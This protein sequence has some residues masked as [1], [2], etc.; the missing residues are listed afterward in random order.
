M[1]TLA[2]CVVFSL[3]ALAIG[4]GQEPAYKITVKDGNQLVGDM[5]MPIDPELRILAA[6]SNNMHFGLSL[7]F[8]KANGA[9]NPPNFFP[10]VPAGKHPVR[11]TC[12]PN[13]SIWPAVRVDGVV[14]NP[15]FQPGLGGIVRPAALPPDRHGK[16]RQG[17][18]FTWK[19][20]DL[21]CTQTVEVVPSKPYPPQANAKRKLDT[22]RIGYLVENK[23]QKPHEVAWRTCVDILINNN[24]GA[25]YAS[26]TTHPN[27]VLNGVELKGKTFPEFLQVI[28]I[29]NLNAPGTVAVMTFKMGAK[30]D[31]PNRIVLTNLPQVGAAQWD[32]VAQQAGD[33]ACALFW[34]AKTI[35]PGAKR[36]MA[37]AYGGGIASNPDGEGK[38][39]VALGGNLEPGK[40]FS[41]QAT[42]EDP[43]I[44]QTL[45]LEL[46]AGV[47]RVEGSEIE[48]VAVTDDSPHGVVLWRARVTRPGTYDLKVHSSTGVTLIK[49]VTIEPMKG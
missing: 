36:E 21:E 33:S 46:P 29:P 38:V 11:I 2:A 32:V 8:D 16:A 44:G 9:P 22:C 43:M 24:D 15:A 23:G 3:V 13:G 40:L 20:G 37:W 47:E 45:R 17:F 31:G 26:P 10:G 1:R 39:A 12:S 18:A 19:A 6:H 4:L 14:M 49:T 7:L 25:L 48:P 5:L 34:D 28:E 30:I 27:Q 42:V 35:A 41:L